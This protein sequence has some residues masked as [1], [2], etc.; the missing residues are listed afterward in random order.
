MTNKKRPKNGYKRKL[1]RYR[2]N[3]ANILTIEKILRVYADAKEMKHAR[4]STLPR[5]QRH[6]PRK[7]VD[8]HVRVGHYVPYLFGFY[9][10]EDD[11]DADSV[12]FLPKVIKKSRYLEVACKPG[13]TITF[14]PFSTT[15]H[16]QTNYATGQ[17]LRVMK[18]VVASLE[19]YIT[20]KCRTAT[21]NICFFEKK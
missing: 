7:Y 11:Y 18:D 19:K 3:R 8:R 13:I 20:L 5:G 16:A 17:E 4:V 15:I 14:T 2:L 12:K 10:H 9:S 1:G 6:M 21:F